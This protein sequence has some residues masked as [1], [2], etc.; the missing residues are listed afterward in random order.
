[1]NRLRATRL[2]AWAEA[3]YARA[4]RQW[5]RQL[6]PEYAEDA[7]EM[8]RDRVRD[9]ARLG[10]GRAVAAALVRALLDLVRQP[11]AGHT[12]RSLSAAYRYPKES[13]MTDLGRDVRHAIRQWRRAPVFSITALLTLALGIGLSAAMFTV[14]NGVL[15][16]PLAF[17][18]PDRIVML[19]DSNPARNRP[20]FP[21]SPANLFE[22]TAAA[23]AFS[24]LSAYGAS[25]ATLDEGGE[26]MRLQAAR[27]RWNLFT[28]L[29]TPMALGRSFAEP[30]N[31]PGAPDVVILGSRIWTERF[32]RDARVLGR[33][34]T[35][36]DRPHQVVG[37]LAADVALAPAADLWL[38]LRFDFNVFQA[39]GARFVNVVGRLADGKTLAGA[40][41]Q[42]TTL[43]ASLAADHPA[44]EG[45]TAV[46]VPLH[47]QLFG[48][49]RSPLLILAGAVGLVMLIGGANVLNLQM[50]HASTRAREFALKRAL[51]AGAGRLVRQMV[52]EA[53]LLSTAGA[54]AGLAVAVGLT[55]LIV[56]LSP[57]SLPRP[58]NIA[59]DA[60]AV[61]FAAGLAAVVGLGIGLATAVHATRL[62]LRSAAAEGATHSA[63]RA[64]RG[65]RRTLVA[66]EVAVAVV[67]LAGFGMVGR[68]LFGLLA[69]DL[70]FDTTGLVA[71]TLTPPA[72]RYPEASGRAMFYDRIADALRAVPFVDHVGVTTRLP[73]TGATSFGYAI[74]RAPVPPMTEWAPGQLRA[75]DAGY[76]ETMRIALKQGRLFD[77]RDEAG[78]PSVVVVNEA[79]AHDLNLGT[80]LLGT[81]LLISSGD[82]SCP[83]EI[84]GVVADVREMAIEAAPVPVYYL[85]QA[86]SIW[87]TR[88]IV[89]RSAAP[90]EAV[91]GALRAAVASVDPL[92]PLYD[93]APVGRLVDRQL[94]SPRLNAWLLGVFATLG[95]LLAS[96]GI[97]GVT[98]VAV[99]E[100]MPEL[101]VRA[102]LGA[103]AWGLV[104]LV[105]REAFVTA[106]AGLTVG[107]GGALAATRFLDTMLV[108]VPAADA[109]VL[110]G[111]VAVL[112]VICGIA[113]LVPAVRAGRADPIR[114]LRQN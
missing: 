11:P 107:L 109:G 62:G 76:F 66:A 4:L 111:T 86:Q 12:D 14:I 13:L 23:D 49:V 97:Y 110:A 47:D 72:S 6:D 93:A 50:A 24:G 31:A 54:V 102:A 39:R 16:R 92:V 71:G 67:L 10:G 29:G 37:V 20:R 89:V 46:V 1:M 15:L 55:R 113:A 65:V 73:L 58:E 51:G 114:A 112:G 40:Q 60:D 9:A 30:E 83:C 101:A 106:A 105:E 3:V 78:A 80:E 64:G 59:V 38:P 21:T 41:A 19:W 63:S 52:I 74:D 27:I 81:K 82:V 69:V 36:D 45:W 25:T 100:R 70:G 91:V 108:N 79:M 57:A 87:T 32:G 95:L 5:P 104:W 35:I 34:L 42:M 96:V 22:W 85:P 18:D 33:T 103:H 94:V 88:S 68:S 17:E 8:F 77:R 53:T 75:V 2:T 7:R 90:V 98:S 84:V 28:V 48:G 26:P 56:A 44:N 43:S 61:L 99:S